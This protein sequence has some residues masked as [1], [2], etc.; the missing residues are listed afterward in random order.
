VDARARRARRLVGRNAGLRVTRRAQ[1]S[2]RG[3]ENGAVK[4]QGAKG[5]VFYGLSHVFM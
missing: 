1:V 2:A 4:K 5:F 3:K